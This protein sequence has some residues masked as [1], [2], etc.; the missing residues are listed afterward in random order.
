MGDWY[1]NQTVGDPTDAVLHRLRDL[2]EQSRTSQRL[3]TERHLSETL[4]VGRRAIR[5]ALEVLEGEGLIWRRQGKGTY[6]GT[7][8][9]P[10]AVVGAGVMDATDA[11]AIMES[12]LC[13]EPF[14]A[15]LAAERASDGDIARMRQFVERIGQR[16]DPDSAEAW[17]GALHRQIAMAAGNPALL[18]AFQLVDAIRNR[19]D[20]L[21][22]RQRARSAASLVAADGQHRAIVAAI[23][24]RDPAAA[25]AAMTAHLETLS[26]NL[27][28]SFGEARHG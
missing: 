3:P 4:G 26:A 15:G 2:L 8:D 25:R 27:S 18:T 7:P 11:L 12:R 17:D 13:L 21:Q 16:P 9:D 20:W 28:R 19:P 24:A 14:L 22:M 1:G 10:R 23:A 5:T 6:M